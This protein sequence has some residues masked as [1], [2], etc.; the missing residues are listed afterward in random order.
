MLK[1]NL[2]CLRKF[3]LYLPVFVV[4]CGTHVQAKRNLPSVRGDL[5]RSRRICLKTPLSWLSGGT[6]CEFAAISLTHLCSHSS[7]VALLPISY[8]GQALGK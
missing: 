3:V 4:V 8:T 2:N 6:A 5:Q 7:V 1:F